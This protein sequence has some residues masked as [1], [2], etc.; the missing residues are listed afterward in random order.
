MEGADLMPAKRLLLQYLSDEDLAAIEETSY[1]LL[2]EVGISLQHGGA[3]EMLRGLGCRVEN[4]RV[5]HPT[6]RRPL[7]HRACDA[8]ERS[9]TAS[10][11]STPCRW[12]MAPSASTTA[13]APRSS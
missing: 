11:A 9:C 6:G 5:L 7:G 1:R 10:T 4:G 13:A 8:P 3:T 2:N 12:A